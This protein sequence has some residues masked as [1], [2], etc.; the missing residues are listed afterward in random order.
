MA[1]CLFELRMQMIK[2]AGIALSRLSMF[3]LQ[4]S[5][6]FCHLISFSHAIPAPRTPF[7]SFGRGL[8]PAFGLNV[9]PEVLYLEF[10]VH[11]DN[12][13]NHGYF[14]MLMMIMLTTRNDDDGS[15]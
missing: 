3:N 5:F 9:C 12:N 10:L 13:F 4:L 6:F 2:S 1:A 7:Q 11:D 14:V 15:R 8:N